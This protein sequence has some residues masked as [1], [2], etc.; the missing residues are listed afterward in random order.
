MLGYYYNS[1]SPDHQCP[2]CAGNVVRIKRQWWDRLISLMSS[3]VH[4]YRC[5][6]LGCNWEGR[7]KVSL[8]Q[9]RVE[10]FL[11]QLIDARM[12]RAPQPL[13]RER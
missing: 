13:R 7:L 3:P 8:V 5:E 10:P 12:R 2:R 4:R 6:Q 9:P 1:R 11:C